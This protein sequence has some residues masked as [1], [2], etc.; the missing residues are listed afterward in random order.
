[1]TTSVAVRDGVVDDAGHLRRRIDEDPFEAGL[2]GGSHEVLDAAHR[3]AQWRLAA[4]AQAMPQAERALRI[5]VDEKA[6]ARRLVGE[7]SEI[8]GQCALA[9]AA[10]AGCDGDDDHG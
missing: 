3:R 2:L 6:A 8:G 10:F 9:R 4:L 5:G 7:R 1:M